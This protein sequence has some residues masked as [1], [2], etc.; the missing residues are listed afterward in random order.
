M[1]DVNAALVD[2]HN[3]KARYRYVLQNG[4]EQAKL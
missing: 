2:M 3:G 4:E 1:E